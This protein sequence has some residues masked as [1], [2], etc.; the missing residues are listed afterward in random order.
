M[1]VLL[2]IAKNEIRRLL[3]HKMTITLEFVLP[4]V[5]IFILG[6]SLSAFFV[7]DS[8]EAGRI[9]LALYGRDEGPVLESLYQFLDQDKAAQISILPV[10]SR[11]GLQKMLDSRQADV[12]L[13]IQEGFS[14]ALAQGGQPRW[15][16]VEGNSVLKNVVALQTL[17]PFFDGWSGLYASSGAWNGQEKPMLE[18]PKPLAKSDGEQYIRSELTQRP[19]GYSGKQYY[20]AQMLIMF[21]LYFGMVSANGLVI[22]KM[23]HTLTRLRSMPVAG[24]QLVTGKLCG[25]FVMMAIQVA[26][27]AG[28]SA[29]LLGV[30][31]GDN[32]LLFLGVVLLVMVFTLSLSAV[33]GLVVRTNRM[34]L[35]IFQ[36]IVMLMTFLSGGFTPSIGA[37]LSRLGT[38]TFSHW[39]TGSLLKIMVGPST[40]GDLANGM[41]ILAGW[42]AVAALIA[43]LLYRKVGYH[44]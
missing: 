14:E 44:E 34:V 40:L 27:I 33:I 36:A 7:N 19:P 2:T 10:R 13:S 11:E 43:V 25:H 41:A 4:L 21:M 8:L 37:Q 1:Y 42:S 24:W 35:T 17:Y 15:E 12:G 6:S 18:A 23:D 29:L 5:I 20:A 32:R 31:W 22:P 30:D 38:Y 26:A 39:A 16:L 3:L 28:G 9:R